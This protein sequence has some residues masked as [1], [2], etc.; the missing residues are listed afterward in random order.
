MR[1]FQ[2]PG[3]SPVYAANG[4]AATSHPLATMTAIQIL[5]EGGNAMDAAVAACAVQGVV[6]PQSTG[7]GGDCFVLYAPKGWGPV[8]A[9]NGSG[10]A[11]QAATLDW[12][13]DKGIESI[14]PHSPH[15][16]TIPGAVD[17]WVRLIE[18]H[19]TM[20]LERLL[21]PAIDFAGSGY[22][23]QSRVAFDWQRH[24]DTISRDAGTKAIFLPGG[25]V[26]AGGDMHAQPLLAETLSKIAVQGRD[27]FYTGAVA[28]DLV[29]YLISLGGLHSM[30]DFEKARGE[31]VEPISTQ[32]RGYEVVECPP[33]RSGTYGID[34][35]Q[36][37]G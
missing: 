17:A 31:Y 7:I 19:G 32:Y 1:N 33:E 24:V 3:R 34:H 20:S 27:G 6:E 12:Y 14:D 37:S 10:R 25:N 15:A 22:P 16:V 35:A 26:P 4:M 21:Q 13:R 11:P 5:T 9:Y 18:D 2:L 8:I 23:V 30:D 28:R 29:S 36:Y